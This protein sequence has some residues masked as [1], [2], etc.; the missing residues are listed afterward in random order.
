[1]SSKLGR[2]AKEANSVMNTPKNIA[3]LMKYIGHTSRFKDVF[4]E[5]FKVVY[6]V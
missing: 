4:G 2:V 3:E 6:S 1:M 5:L